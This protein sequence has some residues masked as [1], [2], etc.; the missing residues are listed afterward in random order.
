MTE[1]G[2]LFLEAARRRLQINNLFQIGDGRWQCNL[3]PEGAPG[4]AQ[5][6]AHGTSPAEVL[7]K[8]LDEFAEADSASAFTTDEGILS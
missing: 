3:R 2:Q 5:K 8:A 4:A 1:I 6:F 7:R